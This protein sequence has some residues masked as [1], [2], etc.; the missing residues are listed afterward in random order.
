MI[1]VGKCPYRVSLLGGGSD[2]DWFVEDEGFGNSIGFSLGKYSYTV[3]NKRDKD[4]N[5]GMLNYSSREIYSEID[6]IA[7]PLI[8]ESLRFLKIKNPIE[9]NSYGFASGGGGLGGSSSFCIS[10]L[11]A[12]NKAFNLNIENKE[13]AHICAEIEINILGKP[14][15]R[16]DQ[17]IASLGGINALL[18]KPKGHVEIL[19]LTK[20]HIDAIKMI[21]NELILIPSLKTRSADKVLYK[22][23][24]SNKAKE[25]L[26][27]IRTICKNFMKTNG[28]INDLYN[29]MNASIKESWEI[30]RRMSNV[31]D[32]ELENQFNIINQIPNN[33][34][35]LIGAGS[36]GY[37]LLSSKVGINEALSFLSN[38]DIKA[39]K[40]ELSEEGLSACEV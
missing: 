2:L 26:K 11:A 4:S 36:G 17:Y 8:R 31:M 18:Y 29:L 25:S 9:M 24:N 7:H 35:R 28:S 37:F 33:W 20:N 10:F 39:L 12:L 13:L 34:I 23:K 14:I 15:G 3:I 22:F 27:D 40:V 30:K 32:L 21:S 6:E 5:L 38:K 19:N 16:Q 1:F